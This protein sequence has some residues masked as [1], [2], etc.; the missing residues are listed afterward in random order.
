MR[1]TEMV[2]EAAS[3]ALLDTFD[4]LLPPDSFSLAVS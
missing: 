4:V 2:A 1:L 3:D